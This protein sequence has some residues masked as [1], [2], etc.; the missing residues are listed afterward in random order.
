FRTGAA[1]CPCRGRG[2]F[3]VL[4]DGDLGLL[5]TVV[6]RHAQRS[7]GLACIVTE[8]GDG[9]SGVGIATRRPVEGD[10]GEP[11]VGDGDQRTSHVRGS[12]NDVGGGAEPILMNIGSRSYR[13]SET[14]IDR[15]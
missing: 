13:F 8:V 9:L 6:D 10:V 4:V 3:P 1:A 15:Y 7:C 12:L 5:R 11:V 2:E 14:V